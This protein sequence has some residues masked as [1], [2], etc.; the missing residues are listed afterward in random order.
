MGQYYKVSEII[1][2]RA[3]PFQVNLGKSTV[4][5]AELAGLKNEKSLERD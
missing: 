1:G 3:R 4:S 2:H 5:F